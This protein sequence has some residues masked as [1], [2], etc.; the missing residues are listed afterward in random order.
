MAGGSNLKILAMRRNPS[1]RAGKELPWDTSPGSLA[2]RCVAPAGKWSPAYRIH[3]SATCPARQ[4][5]SAT[6]TEDALRLSNACFGQA[7]FINRAAVRP[8]G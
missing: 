1:V 8:P 2:G 3:L 5:Q 4:S 6:R 7:C